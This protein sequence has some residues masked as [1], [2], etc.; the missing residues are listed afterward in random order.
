MK[1][2]VTKS[3]AYLGEGNSTSFVPKKEYSTETDIKEEVLK[4]WVEIGL[5]V[6]LEEEVKE[7][8]AEE[9]EVVKEKKPRKTKKKAE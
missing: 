7:D 9:S 4:Y 6:I 1:F 3:F 2:T 5:A 8:I